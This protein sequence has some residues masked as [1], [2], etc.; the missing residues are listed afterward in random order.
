MRLE[1]IVFETS[2]FSQE[3][4]RNILY[5]S[6]DAF[7]ENFHYYLGE[8]VSEVNKELFIVEFCESANEYIIHL[9]TPMT[10]KQKIRDKME[11]WCLAIGARLHMQEKD[12]R[13]II[14][15]TLIVPI[16]EELTCRVLKEL[17][18]RDGITNA[19]LA[20]KLGV[21]ERTVYNELEKIKGTKGVARIYGQQIQLDIT[22]DYFT[23]VEQVKAHIKK[24]HT[25]NTVSPV[26]LQMNISQTATLLSS[27]AHAYLSEEKS[28]ART[29][30]FEVWAQL[31]KYA[32]DRIMYI[33][34]D[35]DEELYC[36][37]EELNDALDREQ[38]LSFQTERE[39]FP[40]LNV[41]EQINT[42][43]KLGCKC[44]IKYLDDG[45]TEQMKNCVIKTNKKG[46]GISF[47]GIKED[48]QKGTIEYNRDTFIEINME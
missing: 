18:G 7:E 43:L 39:A 2:P 31:T 13:E 38:V 4:T 6:E 3:D 22:D 48:G 37:I 47:E 24:S 29:L 42:I 41:G 46:K 12:V 20:S 19:D 40:D 1:N 30:G 8:S 32:Q 27:L 33:Y 14:S 21:T 23:P 36:F 28:I 26:M 25:K 44:S 10:Y 11:T 35:L 9:R 16:K 15:D 45:M 17:H 5:K 34:K